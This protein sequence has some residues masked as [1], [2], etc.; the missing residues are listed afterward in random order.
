MGS[1]GG[2]PLTA[3][4]TRI[5]RLGENHSF[6]A[7]LGT[8]MNSAFGAAGVAMGTRFLLTKDSTVPD[9]V[10]QLNVKALGELTTNGAAIQ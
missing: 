1:T 2:F 6:D 3:T 5:Y 8:I 7:Y 9:A 4:E 10:K